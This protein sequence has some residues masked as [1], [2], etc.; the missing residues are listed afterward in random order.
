M[1]IITVILFLFSQTVSGQDQ[2]HYLLDNF[3][4]FRDGSRIVLNW[5]IKQGRSCIGIGIFR[6]TDNVTFTKIHD[7]FGECGSFSKPVSYTY[8]DETPIR[9]AINYYELEMGFSGRTIAIPIEF[10]DL[11]DH[12][13]Q[14]R[15]N[16]AIQNTRIYYSNDEHRKTMIEVYNSAG[17]QLFSLT[18]TETFFDLDLHS[19]PS[20]I[21]HFV[22]RE[23][24]KTV[25][26]KGSF[27]VSK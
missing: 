23:N 17:Q 13:H 5:T 21:Y 1:R 9:N 25:K 4:A 14:I 11:S 26:T 6:S 10:I 15:P 24:D 20:G 2:P 27:V 8:I 7:I 12:S 16:P 18:G 22:I 19:I 3:T